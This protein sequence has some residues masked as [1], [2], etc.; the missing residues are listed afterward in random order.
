MFSFVNQYVTSI[1]LTH[2]THLLVQM[3]DVSASLFH[4]ILQSLRRVWQR[5]II[6]WMR[7]KPAMWTTRARSCAQSMCQPALP[8]QWERGLVIVCAATKPCESSLTGFH[9]TTHMSCCSVHAPTQH[10][11]SAGA[12]PSSL[13]VHTRKEKNPTAWLSLAAVR[14]TLCASEYAIHV[15]LKSLSFIF[16]K[17]WGVI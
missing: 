9:L 15:V 8:H 5:W 17:Q 11:L 6:V 2:K 14:M 16:T 10:A 1:V 7:L 4:P 13:P 3:I 12:R